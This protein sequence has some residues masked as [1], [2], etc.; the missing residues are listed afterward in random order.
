[1]QKTPIKFKYSPSDLAGVLGALGM[2][3]GDLM[4]AIK[5]HGV[6]VTRPT[7]MSWQ[8]NGSSPS[9]HKWERV[10]AALDEVL[11]AHFKNGGRK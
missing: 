6:N 1:M 10:C 11:A 9:L 7:L 3:W 2:N 5:Q 4:L 8:A